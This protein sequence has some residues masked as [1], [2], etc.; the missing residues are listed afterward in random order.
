MSDKVQKQM[1][2]MV[3]AVQPHCTEKIVAAMTCG[4]AGSMGSTIVSSLFGGIGG[5]GKS[6][7]LPNPVFIAVGA[8]SIYAF[9]YK[10]KGFKFKIKKE[11]ARWPR[12]E[13]SVQAERTSTMTRFT[14]TS[15]SGEVFPLEIT[16]VMGGGELADTFIAALGEPLG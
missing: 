10:P 16:T 4:H 1:A 7:D 15:S 14:L 3:D 2:T 6:C 5:G 8:D 11:V 12:N 9:D 13:V